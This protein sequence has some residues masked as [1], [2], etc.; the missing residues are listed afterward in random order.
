MGDFTDHLWVL[1]EAYLFLRT[2]IYSNI[3]S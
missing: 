3:N 2:R 1:S